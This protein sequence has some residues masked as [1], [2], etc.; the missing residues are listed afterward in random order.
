MF[1]NKHLVYL[2]DTPSKAKFEQVQR[3]FS[4]GCIRIAKPFELVE[5]LLKDSKKWNQQRV[6]QILTSGTLQNVK[7]PHKV[8][9]LLLYFT[10]KLNKQGDV[11]FYNDI[12]Q[13]DKPIINGLAQDFKWA[14]PEVPK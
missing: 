14:I 8:P 1:P 12:Y 9:V 6:Q 13:R 7:L 4:S 3:A 2:H 5:L 10:V 11:F